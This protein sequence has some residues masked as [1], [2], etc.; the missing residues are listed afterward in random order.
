M[1]P[2][3][4]SPCDADFRNRRARLQQQ[5]QCRYAENCLTRRFSRARVR[6]PHIPTIMR[7]RVLLLSLRARPPARQPVA[8]LKVTHRKARRCESFLRRALK[9]CLISMYLCV[10]TR[11]QVRARAPARAD[12][13][14]I[15]PGAWRRRRRI[16]L[17]GSVP[18]RA[19]AMRCSHAMLRVRANLFACAI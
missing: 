5:Q 8:S 14:R 13:V 1:H 16:D 7:L 4:C 18:A 17:L 19:T 10:H 3:H 15:N 6:H 12:H 9:T 11:T 2:R